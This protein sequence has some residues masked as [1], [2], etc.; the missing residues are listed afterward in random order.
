MA[1]VVVLGA[2]MV[3]SAIARDLS[4]S[5]QVTAV[6]CNADTLRYLHER[7]RLHTTRANLSDAKEI[8][9]AIRNADLVIG[10]VPGFMGFQTCKTV[11]EAGKNLVDISFFPE[12]AFLLHNLAR[13]NKVT[14]VTDCGVAPGLDN[15]LLGYHYHR[16]QVDEFVCMVGGLPVE[17]NLPFQYKAPF[18][19]LDVLEEYT[20]PARIIENN[21]IIEKPALSDPELIHVEGIGTLEAF[22]TDGLR[23][24][25]KTMPVRNMREKTLRYPGHR[26]LIETLRDCGFFSA[27]KMKIN[28]ASLR[29][30]DFTARILL[31][32]W[33]LQ[34]NE[35]EFTAMRV[36]I[37]GIEKKK[38][39][40]YTYDL[41]DFTDTENQITSMAR[42][43]GFTCAAT[44]RL[45]LSGNYRHAGISP[46]E[47]L[48]K[49]ENTFR[50]V[51]HYLSER[52]VHIRVKKT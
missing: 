12:D 4:D 1:N 18:S 48:G 16:I 21:N 52:N 15:I 3:G 44:A 47:Y 34:P 42:T 7:Y 20:R 5:H 8:R 43:T 51:L 28:G 25:I 6:D 39:T 11:I 9:R 27:E 10:A 33:K 26:Q 40:T 13:K 37:T 30:L 19:P 29:P 41:L 17:R 45:V 22:N 38:K 14:A 32:Q 24:L 35:K 49:N 2:G 31:P 36:I 50:F 46:P 23:S